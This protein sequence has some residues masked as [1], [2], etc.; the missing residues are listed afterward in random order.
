M[1]NIDSSKNAEKER[2]GMVTKPTHSSCLEVQ[3]NPAVQAVK[4]SMTP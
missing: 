2:R 3:L 1:V 4:L